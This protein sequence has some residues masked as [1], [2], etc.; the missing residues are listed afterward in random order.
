M[1]I[2]KKPNYFQLFSALLLIS[3]AISIAFIIDKQYKIIA[4]EK[5]LFRIDKR[6]YLN[7]VKFEKRQKKFLE[8]EKNIK[9]KLIVYLNNYKNSNKN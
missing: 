5:E 2:L 3:I 8:I 4:L 6:I 9:K 7:K 1:K